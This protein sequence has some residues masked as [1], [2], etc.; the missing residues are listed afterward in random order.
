MR[1]RALSIALPVLVAFAGCSKSP[2]EALASRWGLLHQ[3]CTDCHNDA[4]Q[5][6]GFSLEH[7]RPE[8]I[9]AHPDRFEQIVRRLR[10]SVMPPPGEPHPGAKDVGELVA[11]LEAKLDAAAAARGPMPGRVALHRL[12]R[13]EYAAAVDDLLG[14][15]VDAS[16]LLPP[17]ATSDGFDNVAEVL[18]VTPTY[19][20]QYIAAAR[21]VSLR[22]V[23]NG[24][25]KP[26]RA[27]YAATTK[28][29]TVHIDGLPLGTRDGL[30]VDHYFPADGEYVFNLNVST[31]PG[32]ELRAYPR[33]WLEYRHTAILT[34]DGAKVFEASLGGED[35]LRDLD[36]LQIVAVNAIKDRFKNIH[37]PV[38]AGNRE[39]VA[40]FI[41]RDPAESDYQLESFVPGEGVP[42][43]PQMRGLD[44]VGPYSP[45]GIS[46][47]TRSRERIFVCRPASTADE[48][49]CAEQNS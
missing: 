8:Q 25:A 42:D 26:A 36:H 33:G 6:G 34:I 4:E 17:D 24:T 38:K 14:V 2:D 3:Y 41:A 29:R 18:R 11:G 49:P 10:A 19:L 44:V 9:A 1:Y 46:V 47:E 12:N 21:D 48:L 39:V 40:T 35:D 22:A 32:A 31:E 28:N 20:D 27:E 45:T 7:A 23:G 5:A 16:R 13:S 43:V 37:V 30:L 15:D